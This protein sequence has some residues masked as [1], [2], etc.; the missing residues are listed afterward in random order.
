MQRIALSALSRRH[1]AGLGL[2]ATA[3]LACGQARVNRR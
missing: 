1:V 2:I 3:V